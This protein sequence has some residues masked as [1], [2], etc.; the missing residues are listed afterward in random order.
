MDGITA[1]Q[2][3]VKFEHGITGPH[4]PKQ[5]REMANKG[6]LLPDDLIS[7]DQENGEMPLD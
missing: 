6:T 1:Q 2:V 3:F 5:I 4:T 7:F